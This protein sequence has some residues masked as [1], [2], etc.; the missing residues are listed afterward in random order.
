[1]KSW[2]R[3]TWEGQ[4]DKE[5]DKGRDRK[6]RKKIRGGCVEEEDGEGRGA[7]DFK[8]GTHGWDDSP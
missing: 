6:I 8:R 3:E 5:E 1:M 4:E 7:R 2:G